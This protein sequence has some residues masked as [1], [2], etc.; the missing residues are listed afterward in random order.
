M[1]RARLIRVARGQAPADLVL[2]EATV[3]NVFTGRME[4]ADIAIVDGYIAGVGNY[5][6]TPAV[7]RRE[8]RGMYVA[9]TWI[10]AHIHVESSMLA[11]PAFARV[12]VPHGTGAVVTDPHEIA[13]VLGID[14]IALMMSLSAQLP[15]DFFYTLSSCVPAT[16]FETSGAKLTDLD[17]ERLID[18]PHVVGLGELMNFPGVL[19]TDQ[20]VMDK[21]DLAHAHRK[22]I[23]GHAPTLSGR[24]LNAY[25]AAG[26][27]TDHESI[28]AAEALEKLGR[29][30]WVFLREGSSEHN[31][32]DLLPIVDA[33]TMSRCCFA[34]D[35]RHGDEIARYG[36]INYSAFRAIRGGLDPMWAMRMG[37]LNPALCYG[38]TGRGAVAP[39]YVADLQILSDL[40][41]G[42]LEPT[43][44]YKA[45][46][47][48]AMA[49]RVT[50]E[51]PEPR[52]PPEALQTVR[53]RRPVRPRDFAVK[54]PHA[55]ATV[56][57]INVIEGQI[58]TVASEAHLPAIGDELGV[59]LAQDVLKLGVFERHTGD[60][61]HFVGFVR[62]FGL[63]RGAIASSVAHDSHNIIVVGAR[64][65]DMA[66][67]VNAVADLQGGV[68]VV[69]DGHVLASLALPLA[70]LMSLGDADLVTRALVACLA[71]A[72]D[73]LG[74]KLAN[75]LMT[76]SFLALPVVPELKITDRG[77]FDIARFGHVPLFTDGLPPV[78]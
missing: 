22:L 54:A 19:N 6:T 40:D 7:D 3:L 75:P 33:H 47:L 53:F 55:D 30:M 26:I 39:G 36:H 73:Q 76:L 16:P 58:V 17:L 67:A 34:T 29:G 15:M 46:Q 57:V 10:D 32:D 61:G 25:V 24:D 60:I 45:G 77:L 41:E 59:D 12:A 72:R 71:A 64:S 18:H 20:A 28:S 70:G 9:P 8:L 66:A 56:R 65:S 62:G 38:L 43:A 14:G 37:T 68:A 49:G 51:I 23:D 1:N 31:L 13:N 27:S 21:V 4:V 5:R 11:P 52:I 35:D 69:A 2:S 74:C 50:V 42:L 48:V 63:Q 78:V 44:V